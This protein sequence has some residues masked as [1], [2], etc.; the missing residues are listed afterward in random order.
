ML[1]FIENALN[2]SLAPLFICLFVLC[3]AP[4]YY[5]LGLARL[6]VVEVWDELMTRREENKSGKSIL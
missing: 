4:V 1:Q 2:S 6:A 5:V 3:L